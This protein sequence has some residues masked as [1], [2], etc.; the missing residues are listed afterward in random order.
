MLN[1]DTHI[2]LRALNGSL[3]KPEKKLLLK[4][5]WSIASIVL[6]EITKL[7]QLGR[8]NL[9]LEDPA[10]RRILKSI[11]VWPLDQAVCRA[12]SQLDFASDPAD[13]IIAATSLAQ[14]LPLM[15]RDKKILKSKIIPLAKD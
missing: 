11:K 3:K 8:I 4:E 12:L 2:L 5:E 14:G 6:W 15:T 10:F 7:F 13:E 1:L 9:S